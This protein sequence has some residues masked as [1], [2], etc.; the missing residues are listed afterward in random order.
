MSMYNDIPVGLRVPASMPLDAK[1]WVKSSVDLESLGSANNLAYTYYKGMRI[2]CADEKEIYEWMPVSEAGSLPSLLDDNFTYP[3]GYN[4]NGVNYSNV[5][6]NLFK[7]PQAWD[8]VIPVI[9]EVDNVGSGADIYKGLNSNTHEFRGITTNVVQP[10][11]TNNQMTGSVS[12][13]ASV[14]GDNV[15]VQFDFSNLRVPLQQVGIPEYYI[16]SAAD[17]SIAD[18]SIVRP[19]KTWEDC[20]A[21]IIGTGT[22]WNPQYTARVIFLSNINSSESLT[23]N[24]TTY[25]FR[26]DVTFTYTG[27]EYAVADMQLIINAI[28]NNGDGTKTLNGYIYFSGEGSIRRSID[29]SFYTIIR[30]VGYGVSGITTQNNFTIRFSSGSLIIYEKPTDESNFTETTYTDGAS[31][32]VWILNKSGGNDVIPVSGG[33]LEVVGRNYP[34]RDCCYINE[35]CKV[36][37]R[38][39]IQKAINIIDEGGLINYG[40]LVIEA[41]ALPNGRTGVRYDTTDASLIAAPAGYYTPSK[42]ISLISIDNAVFITSSNGTLNSFLLGSTNQGGYNGFV[43]MKGECQFRVESQNALLVNTKMRYNHLVYFTDN[44]GEK[45]FYLQ[46]AYTRMSPYISI[47]GGALGVTGV[48]AFV[49]IQTGSVES[50][51][52]YVNGSKSI[53]SDSTLASNINISTI[54]LNLDTYLMKAVNTVPAFADNAAAITAGLLPGMF[55]RTN[56]GTSSILKIVH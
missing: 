35:G 37:I 33:T 48:N 26:G 14:Q 7:I 10:S 21:A 24:R 47:I 1:L 44:V 36:T 40:S 12:A 11:T 23:V 5:A 15:Q 27:N 53:F 52:D 56:D 29:G 2:Y 42:V 6:Y 17:A 8:I 41:G 18:G 32:P 19:Y 50:S 34:V 43:E 25:E 55:Y 4:I 31:R 38:P 39:V 28:P 45:R 20:K 3:S 22:F 49:T 30:A 46:E 54:L 16:H 9:P 13:N 51:Q